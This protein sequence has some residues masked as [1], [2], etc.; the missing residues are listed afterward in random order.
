M[1]AQLTI[2]N[3]TIVAIATKDVLAT[4]DLPRTNKA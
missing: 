1:R 3:K 2:T 4:G